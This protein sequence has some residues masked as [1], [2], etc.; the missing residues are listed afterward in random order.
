MPLVQL[1]RS[2]HGDS[3]TAR[4]EMTSGGSGVG[5]S[6]PENAFHGAAEVQFSIHADWAERFVD[7][8]NGMDRDERMAS[9]AKPQRTFQ[10]RPSHRVTPG[11]Q[12][13]HSFVTASAMLA[14]PID[15]QELSVITGIEVNSGEYQLSHRQPRSK[16]PA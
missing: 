6:A 13:R 12:V 16:L 14:A 7:G 10:L 4:I 9:A 3:E 8:L 1:I 2:E 11:S 5:E 15:G